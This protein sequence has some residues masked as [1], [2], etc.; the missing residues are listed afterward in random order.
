LSA[1]RRALVGLAF[2]FAAAV[3]AYVVLRLV[4]SVMF[5]EPNPVVVIW[6]DRS[7]FGWRALIAAYAGGASV[8]AGHALATRSPRAASLWLVRITVVATIMLL[9]QGALVP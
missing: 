4:E 7:R 5:P 1:A 6:T 2:G 9:A 3:V 8:F